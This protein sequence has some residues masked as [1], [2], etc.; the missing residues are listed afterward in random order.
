MKGVIAAKA[1]ER[2]SEFY[3]NQHASG[4][5]PNSGKVQTH[6]D[7]ELAKIAGVSRDTIQKTGRILKGGTEDQIERTRVGKCLV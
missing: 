2:Q 4:L 1:R 3:G 7:K 6:T 5:F